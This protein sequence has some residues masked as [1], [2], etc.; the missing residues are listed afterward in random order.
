MVQKQASTIDP[1]DESTNT[2]FVKEHTNIGKYFVSLSRTSQADTLLLLM[3]PSYI[4]T[5]LLFPT[6]VFPI[7]IT[8]F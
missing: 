8:A 6:F 4:S 7:S 2:D 5:T 1:F 3:M